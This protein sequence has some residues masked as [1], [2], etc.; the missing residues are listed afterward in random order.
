MVTVCAHRSADL[1]LFGRNSRSKVALV[2]NAPD[3]DA[4]RKGERIR[5][6]R[7]EL[8]W[9]REALAVRAG[10][11]PY[12]VQLIELGKANPR[13]STLNAIASALFSAADPNDVE[14]RFE[15]RIAALE[16][17]VAEMAQGAA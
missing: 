17:R 3:A 9:S 13:P 8:G 7:D 15:Q 2:K 10:V 12:T 11:S 4:A 16:A 1:R 5:T 14:A 6:R